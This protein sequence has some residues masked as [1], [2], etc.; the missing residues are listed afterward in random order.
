MTE[1]NKFLLLLPSDIKSKTKAKSESKHFCSELINFKEGTLKC[2]DKKPLFDCI[3]SNVEG[4]IG[5]QQEMYELMH[6]LQY[7]RLV[8][9]LGPPGIGKTSISRNLS[10]YIRDRK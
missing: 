9:V 2:L 1:A 4:F 5:R 10:N 7:N 3:P 6:L 8:S